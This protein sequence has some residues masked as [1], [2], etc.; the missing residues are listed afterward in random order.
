MA[1]RKRKLTHNQRLFVA[2]Y[3][4]DRNAT[5]AYLASYPNVKNENTAK[6]AASRLLTNV[7]IE[8]AISDGINAQEARTQITADKTLREIARIGFSDIRKL[9]DK[10]G[11]LKSIC[12]LDEDIAAS[13]AGVDVVTVG[14]GD[15]VAYI[16]K[17]KL[18]DKNSALEKL[19]KHFKLFADKVEHSVDDG[20]ARLLKE[21]DHKTRV[22]PK[23]EKGRGDE[24]NG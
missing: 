1:D 6:A 14:S 15:E 9:F 19:G 20:L 5:R 10:N 16:K 24:S 8:A 21:L 22:L 4:K 17:I 13:I 3:L 7:N 18:W 12:S 23:L 11:N 2:E